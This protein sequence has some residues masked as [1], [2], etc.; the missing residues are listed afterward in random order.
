MR[1][2]SVPAGRT[3]WP[4][5]TGGVAPAMTA[6]GEAKASE[7]PAFETTTLKP[8]R[9][10]GAY[11]WTI[12][13]TTEVP[14][15]EETLRSDL[16]RA[17]LAQM[18]NQ[19]LNGTGAGANVHGLLSR[20]DAPADDPAAA[21]I[22]NDFASLAAQAVD[23]LHSEGEGETPWSWASKATSTAR[24]SMQPISKSLRCR[25]LASVRLPCGQRP[26]CGSGQRQHSNRDRPCRHGPTEGRFH[27]GDGGLPWKSFAI[28]TRMRAKAR[29]G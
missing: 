17:V 21:T 4:L 26:S 22:F 28:R 8:K 27:R 10:T 23:G 29:L 3:E 12:E 15:L 2:D 7:A 11:R 18:S 6:E 24:R 20:I 13:Q 9:L 16:A 14:G 19:A 25:C 1:I 5:L